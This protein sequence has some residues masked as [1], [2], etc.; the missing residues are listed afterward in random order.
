[1]KMLRNKILTRFNVQYFRMSIILKLDNFSQKQQLPLTL[2]LNQ[3][4][5][6]I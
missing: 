1:M 3:Y 2:I 5:E 4:N 6:A